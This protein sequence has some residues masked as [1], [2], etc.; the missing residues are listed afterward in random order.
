M[1]DQL[2]S[3]E[4]PTALQGQSVNVQTEP[5]GDVTVNNISVVQ[6]DIQAS[7]GII[8]VMDQ[9]ILPPGVSL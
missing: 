4:V 8:H 7:N 5:T 2:V 6:P 1:S 9:I 3:G